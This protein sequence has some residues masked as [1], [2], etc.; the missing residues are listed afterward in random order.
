MSALTTN[1]Q[2]PCRVPPGGLRIEKVKLAGYT[3]RGAGN[4]S[5]TVYKGAVLMC[6]VSDTDGYFGP[7]DTAAASG[8]I[9]GGI[10]IEQQRVTS[11]DTADGS[12]ECSVAA[13]GVW[14]FPK[15]SLSI[16][17]LGAVV[18]ASTDNDV[19]TTSTD[20]LPIG[21]LVDVDSTYAWVEIS[22]HWM[23]TVA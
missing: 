23:S 10:A 7:K 8:D 3:N 5:F 11:S 16:T 19:T 2:R 14:G 21:I 18:Y 12:V 15:G 22:R 20:N 9:F 13:N 4:V 17:D 6:D 1:V